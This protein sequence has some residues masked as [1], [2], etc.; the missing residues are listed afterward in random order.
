M[1]LTSGAEL[2]TISCADAGGV[3]LQVQLAKDELERLSKEELLA[4]WKEQESYV[5]Y[6]E[7]QAGSSAASSRKPISHL[8]L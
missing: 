7:S 3:L 8:W 2:A 6:L 4:K 1:G 5:D